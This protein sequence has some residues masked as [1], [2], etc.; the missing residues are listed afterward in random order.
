[1]FLY[2]TAEEDLCDSDRDELYFYFELSKKELPLLSWRY[3]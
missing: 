2:I 1:M 3:K